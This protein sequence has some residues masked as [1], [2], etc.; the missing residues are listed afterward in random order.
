MPSAMFSSFLNAT[1]RPEAVEVE[2]KI[3][4]RGSCARS[5]S[6][7]V[8]AVITSPAETACNQIAPGAVR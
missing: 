2:T 3:A 8:C 1:A 7:S 5:V 6:I 4:T